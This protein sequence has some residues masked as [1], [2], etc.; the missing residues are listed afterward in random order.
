MIVGIDLGT[1]YSAVAVMADDGPLVLANVL[2]ERLTPSAVS[3]ADDGALLVGAAARARAT[4][5]PGETALS[6]KRDMG[7][8]RKVSL[9]GRSMSARELSSLV[10]RSL[11][12]DAE[13]ALGERVVDAVITVPAYFDELGRQHT[14]EA[15]ELAG[16][17][18][19]RILNEPTA[20]ALV[21]GLEE[22]GRAERVVVLDLGGGTFDVTVLDVDN[23]D[24]RIQSSAGDVRLGGDDFDDALLRLILGRHGKVLGDPD[25]VV[26][27]RLRSACE[28]ARRRLTDHDTTTLALVDAPLAHG[29]GDFEARLSRAEAEAVWAPLLQRIRAPI[30]RALR[31]AKT[32]RA[33][34]SE[35]L[36]VGGA[37]R[38]PCVRRLAA[39]LFGRLPLATL[40]PDLAVAMG[41]AVQA[42]LLAR[43]AAV[44]DLV[45]TDVAPFT[46]GVDSTR[47]L[48]R[49]RVD[50]VFAPILERGT[51]LPASR[52]R[53]FSTIDDLQTSITFHVY[54]GEHPLCRDNTEISTFQVTGLKPRP[55][56]EESV[57]VRFTY[58]ENALLE[59][60]FAVVSTGVV[61]THVVRS[62]SS[63]LTPEQVEA[64]RAAMQRLKVRPREEVPNAVALARAESEFVELVGPAREELGDAIAMF[65]AVLESEDTELIDDMRKRLLRLCGRGES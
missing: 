52:T 63:R 28:A 59:I 32:T 25:R 5:H 30:D 29:R 44:S 10:L 34:I 37:T 18:A 23:G 64:A 45:M 17:R 33:A 16:L 48:G 22:R 53:T 2:G 58:D 47:T 15:A 39:D 31:D 51:V 36:L 41:A 11:K 61:D 50:G 65:R 1:T 27:A 19:V 60:D 12:A 43:H 4:T 3:V 9:G 54:Q 13:A 57:E 20:A 8:D 14:R 49:H 6:F 26:L 24:I 38:M 7:T 35:V 40:P 56:G 55:A 42:G 62:P 21:Y 46:L